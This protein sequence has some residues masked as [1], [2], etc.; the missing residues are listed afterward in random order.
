MEDIR[1]IEA[2]IAQQKKDHT[3]EWREANPLKFR[4]GQIQAKCKKLGLPF[5]LEES[6]LI[7]GENCP[8]F[9]IPFGTCRDTRPELDRRIPSKGYT[10]ENV[11]HICGRAN[12]LKGNASVNEIEKILQYVKTS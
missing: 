11:R 6:D 12:R 9:G 5:D 1:H 4:L 10:K 3:K 8:V 2:E 7:P